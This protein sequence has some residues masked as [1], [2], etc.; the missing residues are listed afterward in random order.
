MSG[1]PDTFMTARHALLKLRA[2]G[3][4]RVLT[5]MFTVRVSD[6]RSGWT[7]ADSGRIHCG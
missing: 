1:L 7:F 5:A 4:S 3:Q 2:A 6:A